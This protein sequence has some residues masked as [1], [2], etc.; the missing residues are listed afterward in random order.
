MLQSNEYS[1]QASHGFFFNSAKLR[2]FIIFGD[3]NLL[4][5]K[6]NYTIFDESIKLFSWNTIRRK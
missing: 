6:N 3:F 2:H 4:T 1:H 5:S